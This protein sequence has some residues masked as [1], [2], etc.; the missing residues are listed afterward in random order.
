MDHSPEAA[1]AA[2]PG[3]ASGWIDR[4]P[5]PWIAAALLAIVLLCAVSI[6]ALAS[7]PEAEVF[8]RGLI[9]PRGLVFGPDGNLYVAEAGNG[10]P[11]Q[12][13]VGRDK[14]HAVGHT[15]RVSRI[16]P[17]GERTTLVDGLPSIFTAA[18]EEVGPS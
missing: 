10:G 3:A 8:A 18:N 16:S 11:D 5:L 7:P 2:S 13:D 9:H 17:S 15:G 12:V 1:S 4:L 14:P 6:R